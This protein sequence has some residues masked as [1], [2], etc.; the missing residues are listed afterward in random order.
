MTK[1]TKR[2]VYVKNIERRVYQIND[3]LKLFK[4]VMEQIVNYTHHMTDDEL[5]YDRDKFMSMTDKVLD[6]DKDGF[7]DYDAITHSEAIRFTQIVRFG[8]PISV[9]DGEVDE[10]KKHKIRKDFFDDETGEREFKED[11]YSKYKN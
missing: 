10:Q 2:E 7:R 3:Y 8:Y 6:R 11:E 5:M 4:D 9:Y 1:K